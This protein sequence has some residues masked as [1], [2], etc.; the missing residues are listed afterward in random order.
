MSSRLTAAI[1]CE[2]SKLMNTSLSLSLSLLR[3]TVSPI[4]M[5]FTYMLFSFSVYT[6]IST[7]AFNIVSVCPSS[8]LLAFALRRDEDILT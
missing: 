5:L 4:A 1:R 3:F 6:M 7:E 8:C 2:A